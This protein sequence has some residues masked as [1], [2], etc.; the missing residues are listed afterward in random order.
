MVSASDYPYVVKWG[1]MMG[2]SPEYIKG[3]VALAWVDNAPKN[4]VYKTS[5]YD[6]RGERWIT[7][8]EVT[9]AEAFIKMGLPVPDRLKFYV[10]VQVMK[11]FDN[12]GDRD[13]LVNR[14]DEFLD[15]LG[16]SNYNRDKETYD[17]IVTS[18]NYL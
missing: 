2:S 6:Y 4:A 5:E 1:N 12:Q 15:S 16:L 3:Q 9:N 10:K 18:K 8:D 14:I 17:Y 13:F 7:L 11:S